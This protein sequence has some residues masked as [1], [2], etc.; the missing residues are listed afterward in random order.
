[1]S[2]TCNGMT[3]AAEQIQL[4]LKNWSDDDLSTASRLLWHAGIPNR[5]MQLPARWWTTS[6]AFDSGLWLTQERNSSPQTWLVNQQASTLQLNFQSIGTERATPP[7]PGQLERNV[8]SLWP[9]C[10]QL[11]R[12]WSL[13]RALEHR[14]SSGY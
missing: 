14:W 12:F 8:L 9:G 2:S 5:V 3:P 1:M 7:D 11:P 10:H 4:V 6:L 13:S